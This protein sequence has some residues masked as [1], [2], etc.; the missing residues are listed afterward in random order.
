MEDPI[1]VLNREYREYFLSNGVVVGDH[2]RLLQEFLMERGCTFR[3][4]AMPTLLKPNFIAP[5]QSALLKNHVERMSRALNKFIGLYLADNRVKE[6]MGF[7]DR[8]NQ[9]FRIDPGYSNPLVISRLDAF[10]DRNDLKFLEFN[11]DSPAGIA[12]ADVLEEGFR[13]IFRGYPFM[14]RYRISYASRQEILLRSLLE[15][16]REFRGSHRR[17]PEKPVVAIVDWADVSTSSEFDLHRKHFREHGLETI[18]ATPQDFTIRNGKA[19]AGGEEV[20]L[21][22]KR[23][24]TRELLE[25]WD[26][27]AGF[28]ESVRAGMVCCCNSFRSY[29]VGNKKVLSVLTD[30]EFGYIF[31]DRERQLIRLTVPWTKILAD[32]RVKYGRKLVTLQ[33]FIPDHK[34]LLVLK[35]GNKYGGKDVYIGRETSQSDWEQLMNLHLEDDTWV[36][37][38]YVNTPVGE[39]PEISGSVLF[40]PKYVN[41]NPFALNNHYS[42]TITRISDSSVINVSAGGGLVPTL[43]AEFLDQ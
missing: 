14:Q 18:I 6:I 20:H 41:I 31:S 1:Q 39:Y 23:V 42:G 36:V 19:L 27:V 38:E 26:E 4:E 10:L 40:K 32:T 17:M 11:C 13:E 2:F 15:C 5:V 8:E 28:V 22:Y 30:P 3:G 12:Y 33:N 21:V 16:Y 43:T 37:Q 24:I 29:I 9:L 34:D 35:P 7:S 25:R